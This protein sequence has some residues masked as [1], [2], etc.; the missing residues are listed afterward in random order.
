M[1][2]FTIFRFDCISKQ[3]ENTKLL[4]AIV[5]PCSTIADP[6]P[7]PVANETHATTEIATAAVKTAL[8]TANVNEEEVLFAH[9][10]CTIVN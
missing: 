6:T 5:I 4:R 9:H 2:Q 10:T 1:Y 3:L 8:A 7:A